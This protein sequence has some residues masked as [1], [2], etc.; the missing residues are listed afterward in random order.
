MSVV[1]LTFRCRSETESWAAS[2]LSNLLAEVVESHSVHDICIVGPQGC[3]KTVI[4][5]EFA[6]LLGYEVEPVVM[7]QVNTS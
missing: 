2:S 7:F 5:Q 3:G 1:L 4:A 6:R